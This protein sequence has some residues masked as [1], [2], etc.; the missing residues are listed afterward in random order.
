MRR[1]RDGDSYESPKY[2]NIIKKQSKVPAQLGPG[3]T[4]VSE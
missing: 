1:T 3:V 4:Q 2:L